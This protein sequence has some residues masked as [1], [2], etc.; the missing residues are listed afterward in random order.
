MIKLIDKLINLGVKS[1]YQPWEIY[2]THKLNLILRS[3]EFLIERHKI[4]NRS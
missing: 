2:L 4:K 3:A 1:M